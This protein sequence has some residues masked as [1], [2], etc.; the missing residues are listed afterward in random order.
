MVEIQALARKLDTNQ[1]QSIASL[2]TLS[3]RS[4]E[5]LELLK[6]VREGLEDFASK[7]VGSWVWI[8]LGLGGVGVVGLWVNG[9]RRRDGGWQGGKKMI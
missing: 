4:A 8:V 9:K 5:S 7:G 6:N 2:A 1:G 3:S